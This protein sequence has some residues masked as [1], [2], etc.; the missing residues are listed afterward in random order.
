[1]EA[2]WGGGVKLTPE[3]MQDLLTCRAEWG[4]CHTHNFL[5]PEPNNVVCVCNNCGLVFPTEV[6]D[7][8]LIGVKHGLA[9][10]VSDDS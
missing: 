3:Q 7:I 9:L 6:V 4:N 5:A 8:Y 2:V 10:G 1:M